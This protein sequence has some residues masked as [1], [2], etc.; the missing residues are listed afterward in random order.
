MF[1]QTTIALLSKG[2]LETIYMTLASGFFGFLL[3]LPM[4]IILFTT[5]KGQLLENRFYNRIL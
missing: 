1:D 3:G 2:L 5:Q 4:G